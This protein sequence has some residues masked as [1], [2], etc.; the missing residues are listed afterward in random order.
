M[1]PP[2]SRRHSRSIIAIVMKNRS[3]PVDTVMPHVTYPNVP[4]AIAWLTRVFRF[5]EHFRYG[6]PPDGAQLRAGNAEIMIQCVRPGRSTPALLGAGTQSLTIFLD[7][8]DAHY[9]HAKSQ[10]AKIIEEPHE[11]VYGE[12]QYAAE[13]FAGHLWLFSRHAKDLSPEDWGAVVA[14]P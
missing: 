5:Q 9:R 13:D 11:T 10:G 6:N 3:V 14:L 7:D 12:Y 1:R 4:D 2:A 8:V